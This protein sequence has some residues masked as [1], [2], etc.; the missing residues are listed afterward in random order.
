M[1]DAVIQHLRTAGQNRRCEE[2]PGYKIS[3][4]RFPAN[5]VIG[6]LAPGIRSHSQVYSQYSIFSSVISSSF[7]FKHLQQETFRSSQPPDN[8][9]S[10]QHS[11]SWRYIFRNA[12]T[13]YLSMLI[14]F[15]AIFSRWDDSCT[16]RSPSIVVADSSAHRQTSSCRSLF[17]T[18]KYRR[19][20]EWHFGYTGLVS[21]DF[22]QRISW[23]L[24]VLRPDPGVP[25]SFRIPDCF[26]DII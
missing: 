22:H 17:H 19:P 24:P 14:N 4:N 10:V 13:P 18:S 6:F 5:A 16:W 8:W 11:S 7:C 12:T 20:V 1:V 2:Y 25:G 23:F 9:A 15:F 26:S 21:V 3:D